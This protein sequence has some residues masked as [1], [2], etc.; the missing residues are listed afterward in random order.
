MSPPD[1]VPALE[2]GHDLHGLV[3]TLHNG[4]GW[5]V[6]VWTQGCSL[7]C[8]DVC[9]SPHLLDRGHGRVYPVDIVAEAIRRV[10]AASPMAVE[11][12]TILG[13]E[14]SDQAP[15][16]A[17]LARLVHQDGLSVMLYSG[18]RRGR[19]AA[20]LLA[21]VDILVDGP[22]LPA[23]YDATLPWRGSA[24]QSLILVSDRY[25]PA[26]LAAAWD[27]QGKGF[28]VRTGRDGRL[29]VSGLQSRGAAARIA[30]MVT[31]TI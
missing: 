13:G 25:R 30:A 15:A 5:R 27:R 24:N 12:I 19:L 2:L 23:A 11:G 18:H 4:P 20:D 8:T 21:D 6:A 1:P 3:A 7:R 22:F 31:G 16:V 17:A 26:D 10:V 29:S 14:P 9:L 28:S